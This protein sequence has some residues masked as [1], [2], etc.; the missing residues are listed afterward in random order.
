M[1]KHFSSTIINR[2]NYN[3]MLDKHRYLPRN[4]LQPD[5]NGARIV[6]VCEL[7]KSSLR[8]K[9]GTQAYCRDYKIPL[10]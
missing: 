4:Q 10:F 9:T 1:V 6:A 8:I 2:E 5:H 3:Y 7:L